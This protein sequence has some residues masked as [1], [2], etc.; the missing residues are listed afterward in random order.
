MANLQTV[1]ETHGLKFG[2]E[3]WP[4]FFAAVFC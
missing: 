1:G 3:V 4:D 2:P